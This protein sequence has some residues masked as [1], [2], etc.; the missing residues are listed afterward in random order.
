MC[1]RM[2]GDEQVDGADRRARTLEGLPDLAVAPICGFVERTAATMVS[3]WLT[4]RSEP[5][6]AAPKR[7]SAATMML[8][9]T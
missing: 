2:G 3:N 5:F 9:Q 4:N 7:S 1:E 8:V 6:L